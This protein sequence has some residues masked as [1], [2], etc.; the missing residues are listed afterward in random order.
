MSECDMWREFRG[1]TLAAKPANSSWEQVDDRRSGEARETE[2]ETQK[3][4][5]EFANNKTRTKQRTQTHNDV[6]IIY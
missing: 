5:S 2:F 3:Q 4:I 6:G 1:L